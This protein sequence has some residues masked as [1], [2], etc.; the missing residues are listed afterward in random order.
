MA[1]IIKDPGNRS[2]YWIAVISTIQNGRPKRVWRSTKIRHT[3]L[4]GDKRPDGKP[5]TRKDLELKAQDIARG[6]E[7]DIRIQDQAEVT[8]RNLRRLLGE[9][10]GQ[11]MVYT[12]VRQALED[13][14]SSL[15]GSLIA[16]TEGFLRVPQ[17]V[18]KRRTHAENCRSYCA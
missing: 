3:P 8:A 9:I 6:Y 14:I 13:W 11:P 2:P 4:E 12:S 16:R 10:E 15:K 7:Q 5:V 1:T 18:T 17:P